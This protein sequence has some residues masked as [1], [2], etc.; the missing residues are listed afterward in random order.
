MQSQK[1][2]LI[3]AVML[4]IGNTGLYHDICREAGWEVGQLL[5]QFLVGGAVMMLFQCLKPIK[6]SQSLCSIINADEHGRMK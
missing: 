4:I 2:A 5:V 6:G 3:E 1:I